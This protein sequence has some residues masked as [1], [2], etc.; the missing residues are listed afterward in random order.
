MTLH[1]DSAY[2]TTAK[3]V[4]ADGFIGKAEFCAQLSPLIDGLL[5]EL[6]DQEEANN[7]LV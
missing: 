6:H 1:D 5:A 4:C 2:R 7:A 3:T